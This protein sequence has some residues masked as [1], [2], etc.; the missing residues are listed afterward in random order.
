[1]VGLNYSEPDFAF[2]HEGGCP[3]VGVNAEYSLVPSSACI[4]IKLLKREPAAR[5]ASK[6]QATRRC[7]MP[8]HAT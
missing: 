4:S 5:T 3:H 2:G 7:I 1:M 6:R 8:V